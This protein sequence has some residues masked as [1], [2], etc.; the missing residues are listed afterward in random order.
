MAARLGARNPSVDRYSIQREQDWNRSATLG[1]RWR[2][3]VNRKLRSARNCATDGTF[4]L[5]SNGH[6][7][8]SINWAW[9][10]EIM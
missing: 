9:S 7:E 1:R 6:I 4:T 3:R 8:Q 2:C 5:T 10:L